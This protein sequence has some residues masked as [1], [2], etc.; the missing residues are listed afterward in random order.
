MDSINAL[1][2]QKTI[3]IVAHRLSTLVHCNK[4]YEIKNG[5][6]IKSSLNV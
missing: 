1:K 6:I 4:I 2:G 3:I 5:K